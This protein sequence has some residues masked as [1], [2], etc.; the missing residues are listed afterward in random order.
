M[1]RASLFS[2][3]MSCHLCLK[4]QF[5]FRPSGRTAKGS[6]R[7]IDDGFYTL[8]I[9]RCATFVLLLVRSC[10]IPA[11]FSNF[12]FLFRDGGCPGSSV[13]GSSSGGLVAASAGTASSLSSPSVLPTTVTISCLVSSSPCVFACRGRAVFLVGLSSNAVISGST[14]ITSLGSGQVVM[15]TGF[16]SSSWGVRS[17]LR[18]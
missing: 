16:A 2:W 1:R 9:L 7:G 6:W 12:I 4:W 8:S 14:V 18:W 5:L 10:R 17:C 15:S 13:L 3:E 11:L